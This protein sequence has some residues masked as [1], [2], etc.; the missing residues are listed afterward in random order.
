[1]FKLFN[2]KQKKIDKLFDQA[3]A[4]DQQGLEDD[5]IEKYKQVIALDPEYST[6]YYNIGLI[7]KYRNDWPNSFEYNQ[8]AY[9]QNPDSEAARWNLGIAAT[10]LR[11]WETARKVWR[12]AGVELDE[13][14]D[15]IN[16]DFGLNPV[17]L[18][19]DDENAE[20]VW[21]LRVCPARAKIVSVPMPE[22]GYLAGDI[23][24][25]DGAPMGYRM[26]GDD[27]R[28]VFNVLDLFEAS[29]LS[30][31]KADIK[32][33]EQSDIDALEKQFEAQDI[34]CE[35]WTTNYRILCK[36]CSEG[37]PHDEHDHEG[38]KE[39]STEHEIAIA[40]SSQKEIE[41]I[42]NEWKNDSTRIVNELSCVYSR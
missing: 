10:V 25:N 20:V 42:L 17:R 3:H 29:I 14:D 19:P 32:V 2:L 23:I 13:N 41:S 24:L 31:Y 28:A 18:N 38:E 8:K 36:A 9:E 34:I 12:D 22:S 4:L 11:D 27:E 33:S 21:A 37:R 40:A 30:T 1:M 6:C 35:N 16:G 15:P 5:A 39:W 26:L 7:Y